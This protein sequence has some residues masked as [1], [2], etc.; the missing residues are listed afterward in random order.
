MADALADLF[1]AG[2]GAGYIEIRTG[3]PP[4][5]LEDTPSGILLSTHTYS[6][7]A[8][9]AAVDANPGATIT[10]NAIADDTSADA[11]N[12]AG[13]FRAYDS[14][15]VAIIQGTVDTSDADMIIN[16]TTI[17]AGE[18]VEVNSH[19]ITVPEA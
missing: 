18:T 15:G 12:T 8:F 13:W 19:V 17:T 14:T 6:D 10:A 3:A 11:S 4:A 7:P 9:G 16:N 2:A 5:T 1:D